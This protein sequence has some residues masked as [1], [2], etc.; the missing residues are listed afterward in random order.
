MRA[1]YFLTA[2]SMMAAPA[3]AEKIT[4]PFGWATGQV[5][6]YQVSSRTERLGDL[7][8]GNCTLNAQLRVEVLKREGKSADL[9]F[10]L[11]ALKLDDACTQPSLHQ[12]I[13][14]R[15][16]EIPLD[17]T[18]EPE[19]GNVTIPNLVEVREKIFA[20]IEDSPLLFGKPIARE[21]R[22][23]ISRNFR[24]LLF[25]DAATVAQATGFINELAGVI[26]EVYEADTTSSFP[27]SIPS[28]FGGAPLPG[29]VSIE[30]KSGAKVSGE[31]SIKQIS[32]FNPKEY[33]TALQK[34][35][36]Q[37]GA[38]K[39]FKR[40]I[41]ALEKG[42]ATGG[43]VMTQRIERQT[44]WIIEAESTTTGQVGEGTLV[45]T[46]KMLYQSPAK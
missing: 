11:S 20:L 6:I 43:S 18:L 40:D 1:G 10:L 34:M 3:L 38:E 35:V 16:S 23:E 24:Q 27:T 37:A 42:S 19:T 13:W 29:T 41:E 8:G 4:V 25:A 32:R 17:A 14:L 46:V 9:R 44:G 33:R 28:P 39:V 5:R 15:L 22:M 21:T 2:L 30:V 12:M 7:R 36:G 26:G 31:F 45:L